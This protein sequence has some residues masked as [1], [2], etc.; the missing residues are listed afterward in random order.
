MLGAMHF[1]RGMINSTEKSLKMGF[2]SLGKYVNYLSVY[3]LD[4]RDSGEWGDGNLAQWAAS[5]FLRCQLLCQGHHWRGSWTG[6]EA[7]G[8]FE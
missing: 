7:S 1:L 3:R 2:Q 4:L 5:V 8:T 6:T